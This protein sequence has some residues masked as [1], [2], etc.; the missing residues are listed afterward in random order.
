M[1]FKSADAVLVLYDILDA[2]TWVS[3][4]EETGKLHQRLV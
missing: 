4:S 1:Y 3:N 2:N